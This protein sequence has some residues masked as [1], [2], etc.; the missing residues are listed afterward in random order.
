MRKN[1]LAI[2]P[3]LALPLTLPAADKIAFRPRPFDWPQWQ[4]P[5]RTGRSRETGLLKSWPPEGPHLLWKAENLGTGHSAPQVSESRESS[6]GDRTEETAERDEADRDA[7]E[8]RGT[9][10]LLKAI[11]EE[12][13][14]RAGQDERHRVRRDVRQCLDPHCE[15]QT[16]HQGDDDRA[17]RRADRPA[18]PCRDVRGH[19]S[20]RAGFS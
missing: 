5:E 10:V 4:G 6:R 20:Y 1:L 2:L 11:D 14:Y 15:A 13:E 7:D 9:S 3:L 19:P 17:R 16:E 12:T 18:P 8:E